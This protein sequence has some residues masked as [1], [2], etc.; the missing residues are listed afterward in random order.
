VLRR[1]CFRCHALSENPPWPQ[2]VLQLP[3]PSL[4]NREGPCLVRSLTVHDPIPP[5]P[6]RVAHIVAWPQRPC[7][8]CLLAERS[9]PPRCTVVFNDPV[10]W[11]SRDD[12]VISTTGHISYG[13]ILFPP[14]D[15]SSS[16]HAAG[17]RVSREGDNSSPALCIGRCCHFYR[18]YCTSKTSRRDRPHTWPR[19]RYVCVPPVWARCCGGPCTPT[20]GA[21]ATGDGLLTGKGKHHRA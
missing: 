7:P 10:S 11:M 3:V 15:M 4:L 12:F 5:P 21:S 20:G 17:T 18:G 19:G 13:G 1:A 2:A 16:H 9:T 14:A 8:S 6:C